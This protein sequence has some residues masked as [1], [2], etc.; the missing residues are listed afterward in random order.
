MVVI[1]GPSK[2]KTENIINRILSVALKLVVQLTEEI[3]KQ[4][5]G[6]CVV[7]THSCVL[8]GVD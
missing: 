6:S 4:N 2:T 3:T 1:S 8:L 5:N 7:H